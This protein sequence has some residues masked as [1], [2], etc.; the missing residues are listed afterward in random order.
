MYILLYYILI[1]YIISYDIILY[2]VMLIILYY[3]IYYIYIYT[4]ISS[5]WVLSRSHVYYLTTCSQLVT[6]AHEHQSS[7]GTLPLPIAR[8]DLVAFLGRDLMAWFSMGNP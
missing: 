6:E 1:Y 3:I 4:Y 8:Q 7:P 5:P 2:Y